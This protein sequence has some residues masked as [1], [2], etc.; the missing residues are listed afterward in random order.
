MVTLAIIPL[1]AALAIVILCSSL[2]AARGSRLAAVRARCDSWRGTVE[3]H[4]QQA[5]HD[6]IEAVD[7]GQ[8][9]DQTLLEY[10]RKRAQLLPTASVDRPYA[11]D[12]D[13]LQQAYDAQRADAAA[14]VQRRLALAGTVIAAFIMVG[15]V[16]STATVYHFISA[17]AAK[18][19]LAIPEGLDADDL[20]AVPFDPPSTATDSSQSI[21]ADGAPPLPAD[22]VPDDSD[23]AEP[24]LTNPET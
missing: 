12:A 13:D 6:F 5:E 21:A 7:R 20:L 16:A 22:F 18:P 11:W 8:L 23:D 24:D 2:L 14:E 3:R 9:V 15:A 17:P 4:D 19:Q 10:Q 1:L